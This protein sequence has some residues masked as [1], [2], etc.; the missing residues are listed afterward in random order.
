MAHLAQLQ[1]IPAEFFQDDGGQNG[2]PSSGNPMPNGVGAPSNSSGGAVPPPPQG[3][4]SRRATPFLLAHR[5]TR[6]EQRAQ[7]RT[8]LSDSSRRFA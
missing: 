7:Q 8:D 5:A 1:S 4:A 2:A 3:A 6:V